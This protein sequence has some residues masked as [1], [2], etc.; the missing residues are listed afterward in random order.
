MQTWRVFTEPVTF[1]NLCN[2]LVE[3]AKTCYIDIFKDKLANCLQLHNNI[4]NCIGDS[5]QEVFGMLK[6]G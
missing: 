2:F 4:N 3:L 5:T 1:V 6:I